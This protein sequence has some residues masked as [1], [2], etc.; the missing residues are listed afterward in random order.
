MNESIKTSSQ[1][2]PSARQLAWQEADPG[3]RYLCNDK[4]TS[5]LRS[6]WYTNA[7]SDGD[8]RC[9]SQMNYNLD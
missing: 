2:V 4:R 8:I 9:Q 5:P 1:I 3:H 7:R 6:I